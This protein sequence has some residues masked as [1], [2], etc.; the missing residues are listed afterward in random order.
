ML[1]TAGALRALEAG[2][3]GDVRT[4]L[5]AVG[6][7]GFER[8]LIGELSVGQFQRV[9]FARMLVQDAALILLDEP[10]NTVDVRT[11]ADLMTVIERWHAEGRTVVAVLHDLELVRARFPRTL[12]LARGVVA[13][14]DTAA[15]LRP[16]HLAH[17]RVHSEA[18]DDEAAWCRVAA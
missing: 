4:A 13:W 15:V 14:D 3:T 9:L 17:A 10:F 5:S 11:R 2:S 12:L 18:W 1:A 7:A 6:L 8:R 16:E